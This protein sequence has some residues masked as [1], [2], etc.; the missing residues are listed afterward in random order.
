MFYEIKQK[1]QNV[2]ILGGYEI[3]KLHFICKNC[4]HEFQR[5]LPDNRVADIRSIT[6]GQCPQC[7]FPGNIVQEA[8]K[9]EEKT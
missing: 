8:S 7:W 3:M 1:H 2:P 4:N 5:E 9:D 6:E